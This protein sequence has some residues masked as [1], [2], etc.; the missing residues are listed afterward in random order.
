MGYLST[1]HYPW[2]PGE[3]RYLQKTMEL[4]ELPFLKNIGFMVT[5][6]C[7]I[8]CPH[9]IV[10]AGPHRK[11]EMVFKHFS[12]WLQQAREY[13]DGYITGLAITGG[14]PFYNMEKLI[15]MSELGSKMGFIISVVT[16]AFWASTRQAAIDTLSL[17]PAV[18]IFS[19]STDVYHQKSIPFDY[20]K[21]AVRA[22]KELNYAYSIAVCT[23]NENNEEYRKIVADI[24]AIG[25]AARIRPSIT[26]PVGRVVK[27][28]NA[29]DFPGVREP[30]AA[31]CSMAASPVVFPNGDVNACIGP[32][33]TLPPGHPLYLGNLNNE[34]LASILD[35][36]ETNPILHTIRIWG[37]YKLVEFLKE[38][39]FHSLLP[40]EY[41]ENCICDACYK[42]LADEKIVRV[43]LDI[44]QDKE[45]KEMIA[46][47]RLYYL[48]ENTMVETG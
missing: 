4:T 18:K 12:F 47:G 1:S 38:H 20:I 17:L 30:P 11:E 44:F 45:L 23:D 40:K 9:C 14:E 36:A 19:F 27:H 34:P 7:T 28:L 43:L 13:R 39:G 42:L 31:A 25:E 24:E 35:R 10:E 5:Y 32:L 33:L 29:F 37:P 8:A 41:I 3:N 46:F 2:K 15:K 6:K 48:K 22:A 26:F 21:N 16:N